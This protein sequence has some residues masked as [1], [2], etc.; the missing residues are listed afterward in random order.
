[1]GVW[2]ASGRPGTP[3]A[4]TRPSEKPF[5]RSWQVAHATLPSAES[6]WSRN[7]ISPSAR[8]SVE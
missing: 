8:F 3:T 7:S 2:R 1:V 4:V 5:W 6:R